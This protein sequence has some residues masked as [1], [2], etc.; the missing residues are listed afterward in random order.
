MA[1][2][3]E[4]DF[5]DTHAMENRVGSATAGCSLLVVVVVA[6]LAV[7]GIEEITFQITFPTHIHMSRGKEAGWCWCWCWC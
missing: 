3:W 2:R 4:R 7:A 1:D 6:M 5:S